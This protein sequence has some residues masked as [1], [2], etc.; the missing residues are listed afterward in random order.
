MPSTRACCG[1]FV[2]LA[3]LVPPGL[4]LLSLPLQ[5][6][7]L[8]SQDS[9]F[10]TRWRKSIDGKDVPL[11]D[12]MLV[13]IATAPAHVE[14][15]LNDA[16]LSFA[17][18]GKVAAWHNYPAPEDRLQF[19]SRPEEELDLAQESGSDVLRLGID[20]ARTFPK[21]PEHMNQT[22]IDGVL[23][24]Y[25][26]ILEMVKARGMKVMVTLFH[27]SLPEWSAD[28][29]GWTVKRTIDDFVQFG[30]LVM[31]SMGDLVDYWTVLNEPHV[32]AMLTHC[33]G[34]WPPGI[35]PGPISMVECIAPGGT[36]ETVLRNMADAHGQLYKIYIQDS[37]RKGTARPAIGVAHH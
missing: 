17:K 14:D 33:A 29:G 5:L 2:L 30:T 8:R 32:Y 7:L 22:Y 21:A 13:G 1:C 12:G 27:H 26:E 24:R 37:L 4:L 19:W 28:L 23:G 34:V 10:L 11:P 18:A 6:E 36:Y 20:W 25:R 9:S 35:D 15:N 3:L 16:W 31:E